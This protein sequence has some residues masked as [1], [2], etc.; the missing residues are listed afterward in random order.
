M[1]HL[2]G[3]RDGRWGFG[4][5]LGSAPPLVRATS[6]VAAARVT[7]VHPC[8]PAGTVVANPGT[9]WRPPP[10]HS[11]AAA[12][13]THPRLLSAPSK[14][15]AVI[16]IG[17]KASRDFAHRIC[18]VRCPSMPVA[19]SSSSPSNSTAP[20]RAWLERSLTSGEHFPQIA[21]GSSGA[22][23][24]EH[25]SICAGGAKEGKK[26]FR[27]MGRAVGLPVHDR[28][29]YKRPWLLRMLKEWT[30]GGAKFQASVCC[31]MIRSQ[32]IINK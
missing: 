10:P 26:R 12:A 6:S 18:P 29:N 17:A 5:Q 13:E 11:P 24:V 27:S 1:T 22:G 9:L 20:I 4:H 23:S 25:Q 28:S 7:C 21:D 16:A 8:R 30:R 14:P 19:R 2:S 3:S 15:L 32:S 31:F